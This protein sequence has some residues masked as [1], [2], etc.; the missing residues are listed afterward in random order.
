MS[1]T[2]TWDEITGALGS[3]TTEFGG[4]WGNLISQYFNGVNLALIDASKIPV[5]GTLTRYK[6][7][8][9]ALLDADE[10]HYLILSVDDID[11]GANR[12]IRFRRMNSP[13]TEDFAVLEGMPQ[14]LLNKIMDADLNSFSN[15]GNSAI[16][17]AA[18]ITYSKLSLSNSIVAGDLASDSVT[19][20]KILDANVTL[21]KLASNSV[22]SSKIVDDSI[23][24]ADINSSA[25]IA[26][27]KL[28]LTG[29][30][31][32]ADVNASAA[33][34]WTKI[35]KS[36]SVL[37]D[38]ADT[39]LASL[40]QYD[41]IM[42]NGSSQ[43]AKLTKGSN[44]T[45]LTVDASGV[46][47]YTT[48]TNAMLAGSIAYSKLTLTNSI[49]NADVASAAAIA[50]SKIA[51]S[52]AIVNAD[53]NASAAI[54]YSKLALTGSIINAD[55]NASA[56]IATTKLADSSN[57][58]LKTLDNSFGAHS[59][60][61]T[62]MTV[63]ANPAANDLVLY[64]DTA[65][66]H[67]K[68][69]NNAGTVID[70]HNTGSGGAPTSAS[71]VTLGTDATLSSERVLTAGTNTSFTDGGAGSTLT[72][73][74]P[75]GS[76][77]VKGAVE[78]AT[79]GENAANVVVQGNDSRL[80]D[81][82]TPTAHATSH[83]LDGSDPLVLKALQTGYLS[84]STTPVTL[85]ATTDQMVKVDASGG[86]RTVNLPA[87]SGLSGLFYT[88]IK[89][90]SSANNVTIDGNASETINGATTYLLTSQY[91]SVVL[92]CDG[93]NWLTQV[94]SSER[95]G[96]ATGTANGSNTVF[97]IAHGLGSTPYRALVQCSSHSNTFTYTTDSTNIVVT[98][99]TAPSSSPSTA[100]FH[101]SAVL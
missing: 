21:A 55:I 27:S 62:K 97:N 73:N 58:I 54:A 74:V 60:T 23:V 53:V 34:A 94:N 70:L 72:V 81:S 50:W 40:A 69:K 42:R 75:D 2:P 31:V 66:T 90:D 18:G 71:Y 36:G 32:N 68:I 63:P 11:A 101:W 91:Q 56:A 6:T 4:I 5:I 59:L 49:V 93:S 89:S 28:A 76:T 33:I 88:I 43:W 65:D 64:V 41:L 25:A 96:T 78:L 16:K 47:S 79:S 84:V 13:Y 100:T 77:T 45:A 29:S 67:A 95:T 46:V 61:L 8:K 37:A 19:T 7:E 3:T 92:R 12:K 38:I 99:G 30:I 1:S 22:N 80:S 26:Y 52:G 87:A 35:S 83:K 85:S 14:T 24:N 39:S 15:I 82:R 10:T 9:L 98:F 51:T 48:I 17:A 86:A 44:S 20:A 57:F